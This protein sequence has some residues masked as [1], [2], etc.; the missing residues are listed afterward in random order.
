MLELD[1][2]REI[3][4]RS[5]KKS[6]PKKTYSGLRRLA[7]GLEAEPVATCDKCAKSLAKKGKSG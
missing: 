6:I 3:S 7:Q 4:C 5:C 2:V 1:Q